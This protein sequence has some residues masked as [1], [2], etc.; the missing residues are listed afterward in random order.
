MRN[1]D[2][3][4]HVAVPCLDLDKSVEF[5]VYKLGCRLAR[6]YHDRITLDFFGDQLVCHLSTEDKI[7][8]KPEAYPRHFGITF[9]NK[10]E[11]DQLVHLVKERKIEVFEEV[12]SRFKGLVE[13]HLSFMI[14][15]PANNLIEF[16]WY[17][18]PRMMY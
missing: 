18:D 7:D 1:S 11:F 4:C 14:K 17:K 3:V 2:N 5:Y 10:E 9:K 6:S 8:K 16:K 13:E 15:D 12:F